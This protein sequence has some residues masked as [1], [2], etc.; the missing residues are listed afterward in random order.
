MAYGKPEPKGFVTI[1]FDDGLIDGANKARALLEQFA[2]RASFFVVT[3]WVRPGRVKIRDPWNQG[4]DHGSWA[5]WQAIAASG[6]EIGSHTR[7]HI[8]AAGKPARLLPL[9]LRRDIDGSY[10]DFI[11]HCGQ[12]PVA[13]A[14]PFNAMT[15][16]AKRLVQRRF[17][18][19]LAGNHDLHYNCL[20]QLDWY[21]LNSWAPDSDLP[22]AT[23]C[24]II[25]AIPGDHWLILQFHSLD[26]E[27][28]MPIAAAK[29]T[30]ILKC[31]AACDRITP[32]TV[33]DMVAK[34]KA[35]RGAARI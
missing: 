16:T 29:L 9:L 33:R 13:I 28:W 11:R 3:G 10:D 15:G 31:I 32:I 8:N 25:E 12:P 34:Y 20:S 22:T 1:T 23:L 24:N 35:P 26:D 27:G 30:M 2:M 18:S 17:A 14:M 21:R 7:S 19:A 6:H 5:D 4:R